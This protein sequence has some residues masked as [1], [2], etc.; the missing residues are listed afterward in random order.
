MKFIEQHLPALLHGKALQA[1][2]GSATVRAT[3]LIGQRLTPDE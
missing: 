3:N 2:G 1:D